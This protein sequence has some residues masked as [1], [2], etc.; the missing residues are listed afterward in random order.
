M[1]NR[2]EQRGITF[3]GLLFVLVV[4]GFVA[5][6]GM[7]MFPVYMESFKI[8]KALKSLISD[9]QIGSMSKRDIIQALLKRLDIDSVN[10]IDHRNYNEYVTIVSNEGKV[11]VDVAY[12]AEA[13]LF[14]N[15]S[16]VVDFEK[17]VEN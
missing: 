2:H 4:L 10:R 7:K 17:H 13:P 12:R 1:Q 3:L 15:I 14:S 5:L 9:S 8:D 6:M 16:I 11:S